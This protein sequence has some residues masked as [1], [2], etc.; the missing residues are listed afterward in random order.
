VLQVTLTNSSSNPIACS[1][2]SIV[3][4]RARTTSTKSTAADEY[5][6]P[7]GLS[8]RPYGPVDKPYLALEPGQTTMFSVELRR[9]SW[10]RRRS[11]VWPTLPLGDAVPAA[12]YDVWYEVAPAATSRP[13]PSASNSVRIQLP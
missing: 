6:A 3:V 9:V 7:V 4:A 12:Q 8:G 10:A 13:V 2:S 5:W 1:V 11:S